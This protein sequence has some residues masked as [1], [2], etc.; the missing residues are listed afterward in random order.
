[1][2]INYLKAAL[3]LTGAGLL[4]TNKA[5]EI[6]STV[7]EECTTNSSIYNPSQI[8][9]NSN[10]SIVLK[11]AA[12]FAALG[13]S[14]SKANFT[15]SVFKGQ[16]FYE[17]ESGNTIYAGYNIRSHYLNVAV[18]FNEK[19]IKTI[20]CNSKNLKQ[21]EDSIHKKARLWKETLDTKIRIELS[22]ATPKLN[23][24]DADLQNLTSLHKKGFITDEEFTAIKDR[25]KA[26]N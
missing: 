16:W 4:A 1:M 24:I 13:H 18:N 25:I 3:F 7:I 2:I 23:V 6:P 19:G 11:R 14:T 21:T 9:T 17:F 26:P 10:V 12:V 22:N 20:I 15:T 8:R 5:D